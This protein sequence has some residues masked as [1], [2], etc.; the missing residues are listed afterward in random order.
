M[1]ISENYIKVPG[2]M[3]KVNV[4][5]VSTRRLTT[6]EW[7]IVN[8]AAKFKGDS[9]T[10]TKTLKYVFE[11]VFQLTS[12]E[13]LIKPCIES[14][15]KEQVIQLDMEHDFDYSK[16]MFSQIRLTPKGQ[17]MVEDGLFPGEQKE[18]PLD[19]YYNPLFEKINQFVSGKEN[20]ND[21][22]E[23]GTESD[24]TT[25][26]PEDKITQALHKGLV[27]SGR[28]VASKLRIE[29]LEC[30]V[31]QDWYDF[32]KLSIDVDVQGHITTSP[33]IKEESVKPLITKLFFTKEFTP[34]KMSQLVWSEE[35]QLKTIRGSG[36]NMKETFLN[37]SRNGSVLGLDSEIYSLYK[38]TTS[39]FKQKTIF[40]W[41]SMEFC[42]DKYNETTFILMPFRFDVAG[43]VAINEKNE[44]ISFC[45]SRY[46][47][48]GAEII[49]PISFEDKQINVV[50]S[51][52]FDWI[53][54]IIKDN[55]KKDLHYLALYALRLWSN[56]EEKV[57]K[58]LENHWNNVSENKIIEDLKEI[59]KVCQIMGL[60]MIKLDNF[61]ESLW[62]KYE[63]LKTV[64][65]LKKL[66][67]IVN[68]KCISSGSETQKYILQKVIN[69]IETPK[70]YNELFILLQSVGIKSHD[71][72][73]IYDDLISR[74]Y[75]REL[76][77]DTFRDILEGKYTKRQELFELD[78]FFNEYVQ[79]IKKLE[80][81]V[82]G[83]R[84]FE[85]FNPDKV[86]RAIDNCVDVALSQSYVAEIQSKNAELLNRGI[87][88]YTELRSIS[89]NK[90][91][92]FL[93]TLM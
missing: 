22:I 78:C 71:D 4:K 6:I 36:K 51:S 73:L 47:Y 55:Y 5:C 76:I 56:S 9:K 79:A 14:L 69:R 45:K 74:L 90:A 77:I 39:V 2:K 28:F 81:L 26:F 37:V 80:F 21:A 35:V 31:S 82:S 62:S 60:E 19:I 30:L 29:S 68:L 63:D 46:N 65:I 34:S 10:A 7:L 61:G 52:L 87:N 17:R 64:D 20:I 41:N 12:S 1:I 24:Y 15:M 70:N 23:F 49:V 27:G 67:E 83:L 32:I 54:K 50:E 91:N 13:I 40:L 48:D 3:Y 88:I 86:E 18:L 84:I 59:A 57:Q 53:E 85:N 43:C 16:I 58:L 89:E 33:V 92:N 72:A 44:S 42:V 75:S 25:I 8:C 93:I 66:S 38:Q 11:E